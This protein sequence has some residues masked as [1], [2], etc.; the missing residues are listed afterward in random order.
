[1]SLQSLLAEN[2]K[3]WLELS[4]CVPRNVPEKQRLLLFKSFLQTHRPE[5]WAGGGAGALA[6]SRRGRGRSPCPRAPCAP[7]LP[8]GPGSQNWKGPKKQ[9]V[10]PLPRK[11]ICKRF[12][13]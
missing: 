2:P 9:L 5:G 8:S 4:S 3:V 13:F 12:F 1:M 7:C 10:Q 6:Q 11:S